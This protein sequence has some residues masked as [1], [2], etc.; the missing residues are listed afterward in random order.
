MPAFLHVAASVFVS[1]TLYAIENDDP[2]YAGRSPL[3]VS[4][5]AQ[6]IRSSVYPDRLKD[7]LEFSSDELSAGVHV[8]GSSLDAEENSFLYSADAAALFSAQGKV[9]LLRG[10][11]FAAGYSGCSA[12][13]CGI[14]LGQ[15]YPDP[16]GSVGVDPI[17][18]N[19]HSSH[20]SFLGDAEDGRSG[21][22]VFFRGEHA[23]VEFYPAIVDLNN[24]EARGAR[25]QAFLFF[26]NAGMSVHYEGI[27]Q[28]SQAGKGKDRLDYTGAGFYIDKPDGF[29]QFYTRIAVIHS[30]GRYTTMHTGE[31]HS[32]RASLE[33]QALKAG[34]MFSVGW[35]HLYADGFLPEPPSNVDGNRTSDEKSGYTGWNQFSGTNIFLR[36]I[37]AVPFAR[38]CRA[39]ENCTGIESSTSFRAFRFAAGVARARVS[40]EMPRLELSLAGSLFRPLAPR[41]DHSGNPYSKIRRDHKIPELREITVQV[42]I[43]H[44]V[45]RLL[46]EYGRLSAKSDE[47]SKLAAERF[48]LSLER[49]AF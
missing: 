18:G 2:V 5:L 20:A 39:K 14:M 43:Q 8:K 34:A 41:T 10:S 40:L 4:F 3:S 30:Q 23:G 1:D 9:Q 29:I 25:A 48:T 7:A 12:S 15:F 46:F 35:F 32:T 36:E 19:A 17:G 45:G 47:G 16:R 37:D 31:T 28:G 21:T 22:A 11:L 33:G 44:E 13:G 24:A 38:L 26:K 6:G 27:Q 42:S 49:A